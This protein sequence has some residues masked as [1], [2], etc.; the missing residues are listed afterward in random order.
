MS[1]DQVTMNKAPRD[2]IRL[3]AM[4]IIAG[5]VILG[6]AYSVINPLFE[7]PDEWLHYQFV[8]YLVDQRALPVQTPDM[9]TEY[10]QPPLYYAL[11]AL[12]TSGVKVEPFAPQ[13]NPYW[14]YEQYRFGIDNKVQFVHTKREAFPYQGTAL[15]AHLLRVLSVALGV[16]AL[17]ACW[18]A[19]QL[20]FGR[21]VL[22]LSA[23]ILVAWNPQF[24]FVTASINNDNL[25]AALGAAIIWWSVL[26]LRRGVTVKRIIIGGL[27]LGSMLLTKVS[28]AALAL[29][30]LAALLFAAGSRVTRLKALIGLGVITAIMS[31]W[32]FVRNIQLYGELTGVNTMLR[33]WGSRPITEGLN[34]LSAQLSYVWTSY[35]GRFG[36]GQIVLP[37]WAYALLVILGVLSAIG[38]IKQV[39]RPTLTIDKRGLALLALSVIATLAALIM[40]AMVNPSGANGRYL[41]P[42]ATAIAALLVYGWRG[43]YRPRDARFSAIFAGIV[44]GVL[45]VLNVAVLW[46][47]VAPAFAQPAKLNLTQVQ[48]NVKAENI[49]FD[50]R[51]ILLGHALEQSQV[52]AGEEVHVRLCWQTLQATER[53]LAFFVHLLGVNNAIIGERTSF[54]G[55]S[56]YPSVN[57]QP[58]HVFCDDVA[59]AVQATAPTGVY[60]VELGL[61]DPVTRLRVPAFDVNGSEI[62]P[63]ILDR[64]KVRSPLTPVVPA[65]EAQPINFGGQIKLLTGTVEPLY[66]SAGQPVTATLYWQ[67]ARVPDKDYTVF[68]QMLDAHGQQVANADSM[69]QANRYP[70]SFW[71][72]NEIVPDAHRIDLPP[73]LPPGEYRIIVG[74]YDLATGVRL[75]REGTPA[76]YVQIANLEVTAP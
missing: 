33:A 58:D 76:D 69:P 22:A 72:A 35:W 10:Q 74:W 65:S 41:F 1:T 30:M 17:L 28:A 7:A 63:I 47:V 68:V 62:A 55:L 73:D 20:V 14:G 67:A 21:V 3:W 31:G 60:A 19:L 12:F 23:L 5:Y 53:P 4:V 45:G 36:I 15:A 11:G 16:L 70:T 50:Q 9:L 75:P 57:W 26:V 71:D 27:L 51:A 29:V 56:R 40:F 52:Q 43:L 66:V 64:L 42:A 48:R 32:W 46:G 25:A 18:Q 2:R 44:A 13:L 37:E 6:L 59:I 61:I 54:H 38:L 34:N 8:R 24:A 39:L 49:R